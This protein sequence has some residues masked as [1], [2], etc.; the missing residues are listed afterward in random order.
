[1][2]PQPET[3]NQIRPTQVAKVLPKQAIQLL[4]SSEDGDAHLLQEVYDNTGQV[5]LVTVPVLPQ[6]EPTLTLERRQ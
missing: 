5:Q 1:M 6:M 4:H 3:V 2:K